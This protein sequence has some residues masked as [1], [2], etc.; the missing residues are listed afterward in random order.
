MML[1]QSDAV[2]F[3]LVILVGFMEQP[4][5]APVNELVWYSIDGVPQDL[6]LTAGGQCANKMSA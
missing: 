1:L 3:N 5:F 6:A 4:G 2:F